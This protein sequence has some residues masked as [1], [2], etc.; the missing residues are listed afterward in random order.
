MSF[1]KQPHSGR[2][3]WGEEDRLVLHANEAIDGTSRSGHFFA[4]FPA[5]AAYGPESV[6]EHLGDTSNYGGVIAQISAGKSVWIYENITGLRKMKFGLITPA[7]GR[8][9]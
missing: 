3:L 1:D 9:R 2:R 5:W 4:I 8:S 6:A 7:R